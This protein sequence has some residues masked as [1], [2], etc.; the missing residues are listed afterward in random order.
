MIELT[1]DE[2]AALKTILARETAAPQVEADLAAAQ[3]D[4]DDTL[5]ELQAAREAIS[6]AANVEI[7][8][9]EA[10]YKARLDAKQAVVDAIKARRT[11]DV[12]A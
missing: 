10:T 4:L 1:K 12:R 6:L 7:N 5:M 8:A 2:E 3:A 11:T 9:V